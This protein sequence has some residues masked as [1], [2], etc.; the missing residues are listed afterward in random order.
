MRIFCIY[1]LLIVVLFLGENVAVTLGYGYNLMYA[2]LLLWGICLF[3]GFFLS[4]PLA[5][6]GYGLALGTLMYTILLN[7]IDG[8]PGSRSIGLMLTISPFLVTI[9]KSN[10]DSYFDEKQ[11]YKL[12]MI[13]ISFFIIESLL[14]IAENL[15]SR[16]LL[17]YTNMEDWNYI[18]SGLGFR[19]FS[20]H[21]HPLTNSLVVATIMAFLL[22]G[23]FNIIFKY[24]LWLL[25]FIALICF[26]SRFAIALSCLAFFILGLRAFFNSYSFVEKVIFIVVVIGGIWLVVHLL[27]SGWGARLLMLGLFEDSSSQ[28]RIDNWNIFNKYSL[29]N[30]IMPTSMK[31]YETILHGSNIYGTLENYWLVIM[32]RYGLIFLIPY[33]ISIV[34]YVRALFGHYTLFERCFLIMFFLI[35]SSS[36]NSLSTSFIPLFVFLLCAYVFSPNVIK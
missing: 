1:L 24:A 31:G 5:K 4:D 32:I 2:V 6:K 35:L 14:A 25:G 12:W 36:N 30:F 20:I 19:A 22:V 8:S 34:K 18:D 33:T 27:L 26:N 11:K 28:V 13:F 7:F 29:W 16:H 21:G 10:V 17:L 3:R 23:K 9:I 15:L